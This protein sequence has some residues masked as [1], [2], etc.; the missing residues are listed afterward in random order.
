MEKQ[1]ILDASRYVVV[2]KLT[3]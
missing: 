3:T 2:S 1:I